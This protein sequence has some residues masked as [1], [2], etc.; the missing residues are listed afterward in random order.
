MQQQ[1]MKKELQQSSL[2]P[3]FLAMLYLRLAEMRQLGRLPNAPT[4]R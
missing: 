1:V 4:T 3:F 2:Y